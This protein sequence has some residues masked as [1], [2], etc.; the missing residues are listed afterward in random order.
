MC[1]DSC[2]VVVCWVWRSSVQAKGVNVASGRLT[3]TPCGNLDFVSLE[4]ETE[5]FKTLASGELVLVCECSRGCPRGS[6]RWWCG[7]GAG[8]MAG[9]GVAPPAT[10]ILQ[11]FRNILQPATN[12]LQLFR[13][14]LQPTTNISPPA[15]NILQLF[16]NVTSSTSIRCCLWRG[17][18]R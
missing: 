4:T 5:A 8:W 15:T 18:G 14:I 7:G 10:N 1:L 9:A 17:G 2:P 11:L 3:V 12:I 6:G 13:N 16:R